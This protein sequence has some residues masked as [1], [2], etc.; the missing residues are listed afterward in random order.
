MANE[1]KNKAMDSQKNHRE[2]P[3]TLSLSPPRRTR[4]MPDKIR[5]SQVDFW[6]VPSKRKVDENE[7]GIIMQSHKTK[8]F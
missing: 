8:K 2:L 6:A 1:N 7:K 5:K 3:S 4:E